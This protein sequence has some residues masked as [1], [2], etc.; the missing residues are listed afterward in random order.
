MIQCAATDYDA[1]GHGVRCPS[2]GFNP[3][4]ADH[5]LYGS[6][7]RIHDILAEETAFYRS[8]QAIV[9][10]RSRPVQ[11]SHC[12]FA[13]PCGER[14]GNHSLLRPYCPAHALLVLGVV[15]G[16]DTNGFFCLIAARTLSSHQPLVSTIHVG[17]F[18]GPDAAPFVAGGDST[19]RW[20]RACGD[21]MS[22]LV[23]R[24]VY[25]TELHPPYALR[26]S[27]GLWIDMVWTGGIAGMV[28]GDGRCNA[29]VTTTKIGHR[30]AAT[31]MIGSRNVYAGERIITTPCQ[32]AFPVVYHPVLT[33]VS[34][35]IV[36]L[37]SH[38]FRLLLETP[39]LEGH[40][41]WVRRLY[42]LLQRPQG[43]NLMQWLRDRIQF[44]GAALISVLRQWRAERHV[45]NDMVML[46]LFSMEV[47]DPLAVVRVHSMVLWKCREL[48]LEN[49]STLGR[50]TE[51]HGLLM[52][53]YV[54]LLMQQESRLLL[55]AWVVRRFDDLRPIDSALTMANVEMQPAALGPMHI[56]LCITLR[57]SLGLLFE[58][59]LTHVAKDDVDMWPCL[60][61]LVGD[62]E[63]QLH[64]RL[65]RIFTEK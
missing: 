55:K 51:R 32:G 41:R 65:V 21:E 30:N 40:Q 50:W 60:E 28:T 1:K 42:A 25:G 33:T 38:H 15:P 56:A 26:M 16:I 52:E 12:C 3:V 35:P 45:A 4:C 63:K 57:T 7:P 31:I 22:Q 44:G 19:T 9:N 17:K 58:A 36:S 53:E 48:L 64:A 10:H 11:R 2:R 43:L 27:D 18:P 62:I 23:R 34:L 59:L 39:N 8:R 24:D 29:I 46:M 54:G 49:M 14:C 47:S 37:G 20:L 5:V 13:F 6:R 61:S